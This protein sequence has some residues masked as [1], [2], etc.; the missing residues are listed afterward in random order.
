[1]ARLECEVDGASDLEVLFAS[2]EEAKPPNIL[3]TVAGFLQKAKVARSE[4]LDI[5]TPDREA[6]FASFEG[7]K[8][9]I[10]SSHCS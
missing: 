6:L 3:A 2:W 9:P 4:S 5:G 7:V 1:M 10:D 8:W